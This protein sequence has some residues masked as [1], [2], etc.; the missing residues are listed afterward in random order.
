MGAMPLF[1]REVLSQT[2]CI[3]YCIEQILTSSNFSMHALQ[4][5][6]PA[7]TESSSTASSLGH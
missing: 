1:L 2:V 5:L 6:N 3:T 7:P 4:R